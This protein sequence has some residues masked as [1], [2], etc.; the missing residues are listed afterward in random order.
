LFNNCKQL[1]NIKHT[2]VEKGNVPVSVTAMIIE[3]EKDLCYLLKLVLKQNNLQPACAY[4]ITEAKEN[5]QKIKPAIVFL[6]NHLPDGYGSDFISTVK[7]LNPKAK[8]IMITAY[9]SPSDIDIAFKQ[10]A[11][12]F[13][14]KP[15]NAQKVK[16]A[17][18][19]VRANR[20]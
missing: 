5:I 15:F 7:E 9:D 20:A 11:D 6:D 8:I 13:I 19:K 1:L 12:Y 14:S 18:N 2:K 4:S 3:D 16:N 10:G 17:I